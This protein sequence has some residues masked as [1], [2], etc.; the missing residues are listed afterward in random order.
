MIK[1]LYDTFCV[2][3]SKS[4]P[5]FTTTEAH[6]WPHTFNKP[7]AFA[8]T[9]V[10]SLPAS[11]KRMEAR[12]GIFAKSCRVS[13]LQPQDLCTQPNIVFLRALLQKSICTRITLYSCG[14]A[15]INL[16]TPLESSGSTRELHHSWLGLVCLIIFPLRS[17]ADSSAT[18]NLQPTCRANITNTVC[19]YGVLAT[20][21]TTALNMRQV[22][23]F[24]LSSFFS[25]LY[26]FYQMSNPFIWI[27][28]KKQEIKP[29]WK[30]PERRQ[31]PGLNYCLGYSTRVAC[32]DHDM[33]RL[34]HVLL[35]YFIP[36]QNVIKG[37]HS[38]QQKI[39]LKWVKICVYIY[40]L[41]VLPKMG[42]DAYHQQRISSTWQK[43]QKNTCSF[44]SASV[45]QSQPH[46]CSLL[47]MFSCGAIGNKT[48]WCET[49]LDEKGE[50]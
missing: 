38:S 4:S 21:L 12:K 2:G 32:R 7:H 8:G 50:T 40:I 47:P 31:V 36:F 30:Y 37:M 1:K 16:D 49:Y 20:N 46:F 22:S 39:W 24:W 42:Y 23:Q 34:T 5:Q 18:S 35:L 14:H 44:T 25:L 11:R 48:T 19:I 28:P 17:W 3:V 43:N 10:A 33:G 27:C 15:I 6:A 26:S 41:F 9:G 13:S 29:T 45:L